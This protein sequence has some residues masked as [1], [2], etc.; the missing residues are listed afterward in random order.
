VLSSL[1]DARVNPGLMEGSSLGFLHL[2]VELTLKV[3]VNLPR[4][5]LKTLRLVN[6]ATAAVITP[7]LFRNGGYL[8][9][10]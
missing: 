9:L 2:S 5:D 8:S 7:L 4:R 1:L 10:Y 6:Q 3:A